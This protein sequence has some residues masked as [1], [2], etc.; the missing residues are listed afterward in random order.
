MFFRKYRPISIASWGAKWNLLIRLEQLVQLLMNTSSVFG[1][2]ILILHVIPGATWK[3]TQSRPI[4]LKYPPLVHTIS[5]PL[6]SLTAHQAPLSLFHSLYPSL[7]L[8]LLTFPSIQYLSPLF[9]LTTLSPGSHVADKR[10]AFDSGGPACSSVLECSVC[11]GCYV[12]GCCAFVMYDQK[13]SSSYEGRCFVV[14]GLSM[15]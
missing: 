4:W 6:S 15:A 5:H 12:K 1:D 14:L 10:S 3:T 9:P 13:R 7:T 8:S 2:I 11:Q